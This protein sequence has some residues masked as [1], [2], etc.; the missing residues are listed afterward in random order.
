[1]DQVEDGQVIEAEIPRAKFE[2]LGLSH[3]DKV[4]VQPR[5]AKVFAK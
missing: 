4:F 1:M 3:G 5:S 2:E